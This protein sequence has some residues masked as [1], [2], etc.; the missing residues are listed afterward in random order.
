MRARQGLV[1]STVALHAT[2]QHVLARRDA[3][4][5]AGS[6]ETGSS[7]WLRHDGTPGAP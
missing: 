5:R 3:L 1:L 2:L 7:D 4:L 6:D